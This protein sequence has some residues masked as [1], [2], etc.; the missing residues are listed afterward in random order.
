MRVGNET[1]LFAED[2][3]LVRH[4][5][6]AALSSSGYRLIEAAHGAEA[7]RATEEHAGP[8][9]LL[10]TDIIMPRM[11]GVELA[12]RF[13]QLRPGAAVL[14]IS[15]YAGDAVVPVGNG[16]EVLHKPFTSEVLLARVRAVLDALPAD[17]ASAPGALRGAVGS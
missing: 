16:V 10:V 1:I 13:R 15:G 4:L 6:V 7:L 11:G 5:S 17:T 9:H 3:D 8:I 14:F 12:R 2:D